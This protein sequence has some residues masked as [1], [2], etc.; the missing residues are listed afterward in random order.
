M[1]L[2]IQL[3]GKPREIEM[4]RVGDRWRFTVDGKS[5]EADAT[6]VGR[7]IYSIL[8]GGESIEVRLAEMGSRLRVQ[9]GGF[10]WDAEI[11][12]PRKLRRGRG[13]ALE[14]EGRQQVMAPMPGKVVRVLVDAGMAVNAGQGLLVVEAMK[15][16][17]EVRSPKSGTVERVLV[18]EGQAVGAG[19]ALVVIS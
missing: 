4:S 5:V 16:Q 8:L 9:A 14:A 13:G 11:R 6:E 19:D 2:T 10:E 17:N 3:K 12:D 7:G 15:M 1:K 18:K